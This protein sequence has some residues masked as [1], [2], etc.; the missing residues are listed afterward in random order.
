MSTGWITDPPIPYSALQNASLPGLKKHYSDKGTWALTDGSTY[1]WVNE[2]DGN[3]VYVVYNETVNSPKKLGRIRDI[4]TR[5]FDVKW[6]NEHDPRFWEGE[7][8]EQGEQGEED[9]EPILSALRLSAAPIPPALHAFQD[10]MKVL[11]V[12]R[13][14]GHDIVDLVHDARLSGPELE[15]ANAA[16]ESFIADWQLVVKDAKDASADL[17]M[18]VGDQVVQSRKGRM[19][20]GS[21]ALSWA[22]K[23]MASCPSLGGVCSC[24]HRCD[25]KCGC[26][27]L[28]SCQCGPGCKCGC[29]CGG[30]VTVV[31][32]AGPDRVAE[33]LRLIAARI[34]RSERPDAKLVARDLRSVI[35]GLEVNGIMSLRPRIEES[36]MALVQKE[37]D[38]DG[39]RARELVAI[40]D[41][42]SEA[43]YD[44]VAKLCDSLAGFETDFGYSFGWGGSAMTKK[45]SP[46]PSP[47]QDGPVD[48]S[49]PDPSE[50]R[51]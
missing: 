8:G 26:N 7:Q 13:G 35:A 46:V 23:R 15:A 20:R 42:V 21:M 38:V 4:I 1:L 45:D 51:A 36:F 48:P 2:V 41:L 19:G 24:G 49:G 3:A 18:V 16:I 47:G 5:K 9:Q 39:S 34:D 28:Q 33:E 32:A 30:P 29:P 50:S 43:I 6:I 17:K 14:H 25:C 11:T 12:I 40:D 22:G 44:S 27:A 31:Q 10:V 37:L